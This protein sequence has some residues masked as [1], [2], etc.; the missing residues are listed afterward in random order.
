MQYNSGSNQESA[1]KFQIFRTIWNYENDYPWI[2]RDE[3]NSYYQLIV[4]ITK[5]ENFLTLVEKGLSKSK[6]NTLV[7]VIEPFKDVRAKF[8]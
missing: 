1:F 6:E 2:V 4:S 3:T 5:C 8:V 7:K